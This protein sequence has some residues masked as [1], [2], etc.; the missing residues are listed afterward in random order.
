[1]SDG[2]ILDPSIMAGMKGRRGV[3]G[4]LAK[5]MAKV[6][7]S[8]IAVAPHLG[9]WFARTD[10]PWANGHVVS[11]SSHPD[12]ARA[13]DR[14]I[15]GALSCGSDLAWPHATDRTVLG[16]LYSE[17]VAAH[18]DPRGLSERWQS[19]RRNAPV[20]ARF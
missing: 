3:R 1:M 6:G 20:I 9:Q 5:P 12:L 8:A 10:V 11:I 2:T 7:E 15:V 17:I 14:S 18:A 16:S 13:V 4:A 19:Y